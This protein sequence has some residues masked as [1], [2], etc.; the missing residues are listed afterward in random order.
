MKPGIAFV[1]LALA[2]FRSAVA[3]T[4]ALAQDGSAHTVPLQ[5]TF[6]GNGYGIFKYLEGYTFNVK[7]THSFTIGGIG[8]VNIGVVAYEKGDKTTPLDLRPAVEW[9]EVVPRK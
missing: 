7:S 1:T 8:P 2:L 3:P 4:T 5:L 6:K 9:R